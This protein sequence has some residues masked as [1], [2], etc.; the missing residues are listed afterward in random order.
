MDLAIADDQLWMIVVGFIVAFGLAFGIGANDVANS[1]GTS[2]GSKVLT[3]KQA[4]I[5]ASIFETLGSVLLGKYKFYRFRRWGVNNTSNI[6]SNTPLPAT[7]T[8]ITIKITIHDDDD[9]DDD[10]YFP[11][12]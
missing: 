11:H 1:F 10:N 12:H 2:V 4:C 6:N 3:L 8:M 5:L 9:D 7:R